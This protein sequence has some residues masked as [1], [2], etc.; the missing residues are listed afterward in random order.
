MCDALSRRML[1]LS[2]KGMM[3]YQDAREFG[4]LFPVRAW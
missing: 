2:S 3:S 4:R 1:I